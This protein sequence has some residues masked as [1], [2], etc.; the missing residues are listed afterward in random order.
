MLED[1][2]AISGFAVDDAPRAKEFYTTTPG[3]FI[4]TCRPPR[5]AARG[6]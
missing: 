6:P 1:A 4:E 3:R 2:K 5:L